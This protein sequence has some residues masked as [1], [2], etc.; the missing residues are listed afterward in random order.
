MLR[1]ALTFLIL[2]LVAGLLGFVVLA[3]LAAS[4][5]KLL[6]IVFVVLFIVSFVF[7]RGAGNAPRV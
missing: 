7:G 6:I 3:G 2:A 1:L 5:A 4:I